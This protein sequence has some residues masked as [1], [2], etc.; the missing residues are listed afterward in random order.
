M[1]LGFRARLLLRFR[2]LARL[3]IEWRGHDQI[4]T[5]LRGFGEPV[6]P[7]RIEIRRSDDTELDPW[8]WNWNDPLLPQGEFRC[9]RDGELYAITHNGIGGPWIPAPEQP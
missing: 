9:Y 7:P 4:A 3:L 1:R 5:D 6:D 2:W 8:E